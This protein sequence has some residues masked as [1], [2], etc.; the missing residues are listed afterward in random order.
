MLIQSA[1]KIIFSKFVYEEIRQSPHALCQPSRKA[2]TSA[3][4][5]SSTCGNARLMSA[6]AYPKRS[7]GFSPLTPPLASA[8][9][10][11]LGSCDNGADRTMDNGEPI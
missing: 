10:V 4:N 11:A 3:C 7:W 9:A 1:Q 2:F 8:L 6:I 5:P